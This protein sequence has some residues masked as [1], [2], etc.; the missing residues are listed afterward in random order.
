MP[1]TLV[2]LNDDLLSLLESDLASKAQAAFV[3]SG[4]AS[5]IYGVFS[6]DDLEAKQEKELGHNVAVGIAYSGSQ[7]LAIDT[8]PGASAAPG[9]GMSARMLQYEF[10]VLLAV[11][12][13]QQCEERYNAT[14]LLTVLRRRI[15][16]S[17]VADDDG[18][19]RWSFL[20]EAPRV[21]QSTSTMLY[22]TQYWSVALPLTGST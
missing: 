15:H 14:K 12:T 8:R 17:K 20:K 1:V 16:G 19:R 4:V 21:D 2:H 3:S 11:P 7:P 13:D 18:S 5:N 6:L 22:Y 9:Q 10:L